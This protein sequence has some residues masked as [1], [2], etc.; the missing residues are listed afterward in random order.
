MCFVTNVMINP[1]IEIDSVSIVLVVLYTKVESVL[2]TYSEV[3][4]MSRI[5]TTREQTHTQKYINTKYV[6]RSVNTGHV[7]TDYT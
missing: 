6:N 2:Q 4:N 1:I 5:N 7:G 3:Y